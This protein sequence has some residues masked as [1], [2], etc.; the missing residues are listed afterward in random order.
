MKKYPNL[1]EIHN[2]DW[3]KFKCIICGEKNTD[4]VI[5]VKFSPH[6]N[7]WKPFEAHQE[8]IENKSKNQILKMVLTA[9]EEKLVKRRKEKWTKLQQLA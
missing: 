1:S 4:R 3:Y 2:R 6:K 8:C 7:D 9:K 5:I